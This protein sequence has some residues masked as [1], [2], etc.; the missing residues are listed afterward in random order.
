MSSAAKIDF[1]NYF[2]L[3]ATSLE[4]F[5]IPGLG[6]FVWHIERAEVDPKAAQIKPPRP[7]LKYEPGQRYVTETI[8]F[9][10]DRYGL[11]PEESEAFLKELGNILVNYLKAASEMDVWKLGKLRRAGVSYRLELG[12]GAPLGFLEDL[13]PVS[14]RHSEGAVAP[15][16]VSGQPAAKPPARKAEKEKA[17]RE[18]SRAR[19]VEVS[20]QPSE[21][22]APGRRGLAWIGVVF[23]VLVIIAV[24]AYFILRKRERAAHQPVEIVLGHKQEKSIQDSQTPETSSSSESEK[25]AVRPSTTES[26]TKKSAPTQPSPASSSSGGPSQ[27]PS[28]S[29]SE[30]DKGPSIKPSA[31]PAPSSAQPA[32]TNPIKG[33]YYII[34]GSY[35]SLAEAQEKAKTLESSTIEFLPGKEGRVR[36]SYYS[37]SNA[38]EAQARLKEVKARIPD[39]WVY[40]P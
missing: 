40:T 37:S 35:P 34:V 3:L 29:R 1:E 36:I 38:A 6:S 2:A 39:A 33:R 12:E 7:Q 30:A 8:A 19:S 27:K 17:P 16:A 18:S 10:V 5:S 20:P 28:T 11:S 15:I 13:H 9:F 24:G 22:K 32:L 23:L 26:E 25:P 14:L 21:G 4:R 31:P